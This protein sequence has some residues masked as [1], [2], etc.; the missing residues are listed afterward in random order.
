MEKI[1]KN[2]W[3]YIVG[4]VVCFLFRLIPF[5]PPNI[6]LILTAQMPFARFYGKFAGFS[7]AF[8]SIFLYDI[9]TNKLGIWSLITGLTYGLL[10]LFA[11]SYFKNKKNNAWDYAKFAII[12]TILYDAITGLS[13]GPLFFNQSFTQAL[14]GQ[15]PFTLLHL[16]GNVSFALI[17]S[18]AIYTYILKNKKLE[19]A[20]I[21]TIFNLKNL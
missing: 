5:K 15:I 7:F 14:V 4:F 6:E 9:F 3:Q 13:I 19:S 1:K 21:I 20:S 18:P 17:L 12:G 16:I 8:F 2:Y 11:V 10:G